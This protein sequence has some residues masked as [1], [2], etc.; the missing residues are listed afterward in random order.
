MTNLTNKIWSAVF[1]RCPAMQRYAHWKIAAVKLLYWK[2]LSCFFITLVFDNVGKHFSNH[3]KN[4]GRTVIFGQ[5][6]Y[7]GFI[8][9]TSLTPLLIIRSFWHYRVQ[10]IW[11]CIDPK[12]LFFHLSWWKEPTARTIRFWSIWTKGFLWTHLDP[13]FSYSW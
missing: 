2:T 9:F 13:G 3:I 8:Y 5:K 4:L 12:R 6:T 7:F 11:R 10:G 1:W